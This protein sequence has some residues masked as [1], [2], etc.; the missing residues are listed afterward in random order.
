MPAWGLGG[1][2]GKNS[3][4]Q[5]QI[6]LQQHHGCESGGMVMAT[7][8]DLTDCPFAWLLGDC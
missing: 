5:A 8:A 7:L 2:I 4:D 1:D 6:N 3:W